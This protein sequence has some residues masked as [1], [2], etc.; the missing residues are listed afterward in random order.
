MRLEKMPN[1]WISV[2]E[3]HPTLYDIVLVYDSGENVVTTA[4]MQSDGTWLANSGGGMAIK[5]C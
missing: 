2:E 5:T 3:K 1:K 4:A